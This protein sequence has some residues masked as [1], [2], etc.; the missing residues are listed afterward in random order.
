MTTIAVFSD[1]HGNLAALE[2]VYADAIQHG[3]GATGS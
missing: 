1:I 3:S 2:A